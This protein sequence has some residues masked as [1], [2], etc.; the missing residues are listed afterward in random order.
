MLETTFRQI[1]LTGDPVKAAPVLVNR[2]T[3]HD[4]GRAEVLRHLIVESDLTVWGLANAVSNYSQDVADDDRATDF[5]ALGASSLSCR[6]VIAG[7]W[8]RWGAEGSLWAGLPR[9][10]VTR[11]RKS[12]RG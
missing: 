1:A 7:R 10:F 8:W 9:R 4:T 3:L 12:Q 5:E 2:Y 11:G 6:K